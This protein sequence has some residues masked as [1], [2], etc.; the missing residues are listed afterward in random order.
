M[1]VYK[2]DILDVE[3]NTGNIARSFLCHN[4]GK[5][6]QKA[7]RFGVRC[8][9]DG[10]P[11]SLSGVSIQGFMLRPNGSHFHI[12]G[13]ANTGVSG[14]EAWVDLPQ[15][16]YDYEGQFCLALKLIG[17]EVTG[18]IRIIDGMV[19]N[20]FVDGA[21][22]P[23]AAVPTYQ[24][25]LSVYDQMVAAKA[26]SVRFDTDQA[27]TAAQMTQARGNIEA[28]S[29]SDVS[30][31]KSAFNNVD[32][33]YVY[34]TGYIDCS[35]S[36]VDPTAIT[37]SS[38]YKHV[39]V[40]CTEG[41]VFLVNGTG[42][43]SARVWCFIDSSNNVVAI[44]VNDG[45]FKADRQ[46]IIA[47]Q[48]ATKL[49]SNYRVSLTANPALYKLAFS[50]YFSLVPNGAADI[51]ANANIDNYTNAGSFYVRTVAIA[52]SLAHWPSSVGGRLIVIKLTSNAQYFQCVVDNDG[53]IFT[54]A[55]SGSNAWSEWTRVSTKEYVDTLMERVGT[56]VSTGFAQST[57][58]PS[59]SDLN[60]YVTPGNYVIT[61]T[62]IA[63]SLINRPVAYSGRLTV[64]Q[65]A[66]K[67]NIFQIYISTKMHVLI[68][69]KD[70][71]GWW[72]WQSIKP[73]YH[74]M[75]ADIIPADSNMDD[76]II[77]GTYCVAS[78]ANI[79]FITKWPSTLA[80]RL[81]VY[82]INNSSL[83]SQIIIDADDRI[84]TR[85]KNNSGW[86]E[87]GEIAKISD[88]PEV[89]P[90]VIL[91]QTDVVTIPANSDLD[92]Y[93]TVGTYRI[94]SAANA[95][96]VVHCPSSLAGKIIISTT[97]SINS[98]HQIY[99]ANDGQVYVRVFS[100]GVW[101]DWVA[102]NDESAFIENKMDSLGVMNLAHEIK[103][104]STYK[105]SYANGVTPLKL[106]NYI[107]NIQNVHPKVL[108]FENGFGGHK[109]W[110]AYTPYPYSNDKHEN[111]CVAYSNDGFMWVNINANPL[112]DPGG[113]GYNSD[114]HLVYRSDTGVLEC[115]YRYVGD[116]SDSPREETIF[117]R[118]TTDGITWTAEEQIYSNTSG[119]YSRILS[120][121]IIFENNI[122]K[123]WCVQQKNNDPVTIAYYEAPATDATAWVKIREINLTYTDN[124]IRVY[125][126]HMDVIKDGDTY[127]LLVMCRNGT[128][129]ANNHCSLFITTS[130]DNTNYSTPYIV[131]E[132]SAIGWDRYMYRSSIVKVG[133]VYRIYYSAGTG[134]AT[135]IYS[136][137]V[138]GIGVTES[139]TLNNFIG[140]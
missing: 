46:I 41:D 47:P 125:P 108:Y 127:I 105:L 97:N 1:A 122:Y 13:S 69:G 2:A 58:I 67:S 80:G 64:I 113:H 8:F 139:E 140:Y 109:Y 126:W 94:A 107:G 112:S 23:T 5:D 99:L 31:L 45:T 81:F 110:M 9:R 7:D 26:G 60:D 33:Q 115:W 63:E 3:L 53:N 119:N 101:L 135:T 91:D 36:T 16:A 28:A 114:T 84:F 35:G 34:E 24:E 52:S 6:D 116:A 15:E 38:N 22:A 123:I 25:I 32:A 117:R 96:T 44:Q 56:P 59:G 37:Q 111:P 103:S 51:Q 4:I 20:T 10:E 12:H 73:G 61:T 14:N 138:W 77:P 70:N 71:S 68:R 57:A 48:S 129:I 79:P 76:Y 17:G 75:D 74:Y 124:G 27:L 50:E 92:D 42:A 130:T 102:C 55:K 86:S 65:T 19:N 83:V 49:I 78:A 40:D 137:S 88:I 132:G 95:Q 39:V 133:N 128:S 54:R 131:V 98:Y 136:S 85:R 134:G 29:E 43:V 106:R 21:V 18:T 11:V 118:T 89:K 90:S 120:P 82:Q 62:A 66:S 30:D 121:A 100:S 93:K 104:E 87:W 72:K